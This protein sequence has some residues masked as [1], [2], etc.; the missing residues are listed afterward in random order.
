M[1]S[2]RYFFSIGLPAFLG[3][4]LL[5]NAVWAANPIQT[6]SSRVYAASSENLNPV[7]QSAAKQGVKS[8]LKRIDQITNFLG[9]GANA[10]ISLFPAPS[11]V[12]RRLF[13]LAMEVDLPGTLSYAGA[14][15]AP[16]GTDNCDAEYQAVTYVPMNCQNLAARNFSQLKSLGVMKQSIQMLDGGPNMRVFLMPAGQGCV[17]IKKEMAY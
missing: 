12:D 2:K 6:P 17:V 4:G 1:I 7:A 11:I 8:C 14:S 13:S 9:K 15:F 10:G 16:V 3:L 5:S